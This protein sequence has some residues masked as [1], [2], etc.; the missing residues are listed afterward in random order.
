MLATS[1]N[2]DAKLQD[3]IAKMKRVT[4]KPLDSYSHE[5]KFL[6]QHLVDIQPTQL[7]SAPPAGMV[8]IPGATFGFKVEGIEIEGSDDVGVDVQYPWEDAPRRFHEHSIEI[9]PFYMSKYPVTNAEFKKFLDATH[10]HPRDDHNFLKHWTN[11][12]YPPD[13]A[14]QPVVW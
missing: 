12:T 11:G 8:L 3:L 14:N 1:V 13:A 10:Y 4:E 9:K 7:A 6:P 2:P 5:W